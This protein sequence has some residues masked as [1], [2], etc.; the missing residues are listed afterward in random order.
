M[1]HFKRN[2]VKGISEVHIRIKD[3][4]MRL[5]H[6]MKATESSTSNL[7]KAKQNKTYFSQILGNFSAAFSTSPIITYNFCKHVIIRKIER[8]TLFTD[9]W[10]VIH[11]QMPKGEN[12]LKLFVEQCVKH[13]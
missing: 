3:D 6:F 4:T 2:A 9:I 13:Y 12:N 10:L 1:V 11:H 7:M 8:E 5:S